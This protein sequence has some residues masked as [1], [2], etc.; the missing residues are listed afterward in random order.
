[1]AENVLYHHGRTP[2]NFIFKRRRLRIDRCKKSQQAMKA[3]ATAG[4]MN[5]NISS[6]VS[7]PIANVHYG[8]FI[9]G[10]AM[11]NIT[12]ANNVDDFGFIAHRLVDNERNMHI[13]LQIDERERKFSIIIS[14]TGEYSS[15]DLA[16]EWT[17]NA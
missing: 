5:N 12:G 4:S 13:R 17:F 3:A 8:T 6:V 15:T 16:F 9:V 10:T 14:C 1:M 2:Q 7:F 11:R